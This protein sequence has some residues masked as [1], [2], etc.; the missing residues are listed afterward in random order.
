MAELSASAHPP[1]FHSYRSPVVSRRGMV[2]C[3]Q[4]LASQA[5]LS[6]LMK[7]GNAAD[8]AVAMAPTLNVTQTASA[9]LWGDCFAL[10][11]ASQNPKSK[12]LKRACLPPVRV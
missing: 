9:R 10:F 11:Y 3:S 12:R 7:G 5:G 1:A 6:I 4:P 8:A 2:A